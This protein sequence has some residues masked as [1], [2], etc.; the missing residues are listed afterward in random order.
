M[1]VAGRAEF[2]PARGLQR[3]V[4]GLK[5]QRALVRAFVEGLLGVHHV[6]ELHA[7]MKQAAGLRS[8][9]DWNCAVRQVKRASSDAAE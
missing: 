2:E 1:T 4:A 7:C 3:L 5:A 8:L 9:F 6:R